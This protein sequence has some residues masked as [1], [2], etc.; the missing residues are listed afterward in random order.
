MTLN[1]TQDSLDTAYEDDMDSNKHDLVEDDELN[2]EL[3]AGENARAEM[4]LDASIQKGKNV[5]L[6]RRKRTKMEAVTG[7]NA[8]SVESARFYRWKSLFRLFVASKHPIVTF[9]AFL[10]FIC[11]A[12]QN[13]RWL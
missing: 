12:F 4:R 2:E 10:D 11:D 6:H 5:V 3:Q 1:E 9:Y 13:L 7:K 8:P